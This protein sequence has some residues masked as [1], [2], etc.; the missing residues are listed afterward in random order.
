MQ[1][2]TLGIDMLVAGFVFL[3]PP[4]LASRLKQI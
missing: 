1:I 2:I 4:L 3:S